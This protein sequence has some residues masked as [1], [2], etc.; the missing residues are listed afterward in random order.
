MNKCKCG[1]ELSKSKYKYCRKCSI[2]LQFKDGR[3]NYKGKHHPGFKGG[4]PKCE[5]CG[6]QLIRRNSKRCHPHSFEIRVNPLKR[7]FSKVLLVKEYIK[8]KLSAIEL[9]LKYKCSSTTIYKYLELN[10]INRRALKEALKET[11]DGDK[12]GR[13]I[14]GRSYLKYPLEFN[15]FRKFIRERDNYTCQKCGIT[16]KEYKKKAKRNLDI[17]HKDHNKE[18]NDKSNLITLCRK[19]HHSL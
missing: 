17:H 6:K 4:F 13:W 19:C 18:N 1:K 14:D 16:E 9:G 3:R 15:K 12:N 11:S 8:N 2:K 7:S 5:I 10:G